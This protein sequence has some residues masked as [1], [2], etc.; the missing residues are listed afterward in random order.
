MSVAISYVKPKVG[1]PVV[2]LAIAA[3][4]GLTCNSLS[5][6]IDTRY[7]EVPLT[8]ARYIIMDN[9]LD[10]RFLYCKMDMEYFDGSGSDNCT[11]TVAQFRF[12]AKIVKKYTKRYSDHDLLREVLDKLTTM[13]PTK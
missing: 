8:I 1:F 9:R 13:L 4:F 12:V 5:D 3:L 11:H 6:T 10:R 2:P 7:T